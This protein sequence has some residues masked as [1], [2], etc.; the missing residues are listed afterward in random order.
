MLPSFIE[1]VG[2]DLLVGHCIDLDMSFIHRA[3]R[4]VY[5]G[6]L[7]NPGIDTI[8]LAQG[9]KQVVRGRYEEPGITSTSYRLEDLSREFDLPLFEPH[10]ALEDALQT[11]YLFLYLIKKFRK[12]GLTTLQE[13]Y[14]AG[15][16]GIMQVI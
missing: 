3:T 5:G 12:G 8:R 16:P 11:A 7:V 4:Q 15:K 6:T 10:D 9:Y 2:T 1:F 13:L 14:R